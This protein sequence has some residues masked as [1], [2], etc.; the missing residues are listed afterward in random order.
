MPLGGTSSGSGAST[1]AIGGISG[2]RKHKVGK[3]SGSLMSG[4]TAGGKWWVTVIVDN[5]Q[6]Q[7][8]VGRK[9]R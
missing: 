5:K 8:R 6:T 7:I 4:I 2:W 1:G 3:R 9:G